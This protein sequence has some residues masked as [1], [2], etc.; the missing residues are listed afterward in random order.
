MYFLWIQEELM[1]LRM[2]KGTGAY[3][4]LAFYLPKARQLAQKTPPMKLMKT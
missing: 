2:K 4:T 3:L 1:I